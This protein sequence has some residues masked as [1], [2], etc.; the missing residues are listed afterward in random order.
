MNNIYID[1]YIYIYTH[2]FICHLKLSSLKFGHSFVAAAKKEVL[3]WYP[4]PLFVMGSPY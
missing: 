1:I 4:F 2:I 3:Q